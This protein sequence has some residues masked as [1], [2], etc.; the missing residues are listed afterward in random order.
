[1]ELEAKCHCFAGAHEHAVV[2]QRAV[3]DGVDLDTV[4][5]AAHL[6]NPVRAA[7]VG[8]R[9]LPATVDAHQSGADRL[10][11]ERVCDASRDGPAGLR[12]QWRSSREQRA[13]EAQGTA[14]GSRTAQISELP[15]AIISVT[16]RSPAGERAGCRNSST[17]DVSARCT[18]VARLTR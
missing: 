7:A 1:M 8:R 10:P 14:H 18:P 11:G 3:P 5:A 2:D 9:A 15:P 6:A 13:R 16:K 17:P 12:P 4:P